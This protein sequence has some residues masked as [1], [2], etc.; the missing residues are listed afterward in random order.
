MIDHSFLFHEALLSIGWVFERLCFVRRCVVGYD[1]GGCIPYCGRDG[2]CFIS[3]ILP[4]EE[5]GVG[6]DDVL[7]LSVSCGNK[8]SIFDFL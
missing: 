4:F 6:G 5:C 8:Y 7:V 1:L 2:L 3:L